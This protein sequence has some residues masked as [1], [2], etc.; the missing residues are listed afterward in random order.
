MFAKVL[1]KSN[2]ECV[3]RRSGRVLDADKPGWANV[4]TSATFEG[5]VLKCFADDLFPI[6]AITGAVK[7]HGF[8]N[9]GG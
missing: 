2:V 1:T 5:V 8:W 9:V 6:F 3:P 7:Y 4:N